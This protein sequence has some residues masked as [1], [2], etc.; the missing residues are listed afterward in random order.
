LSKLVKKTAP[1]EESFIANARRLASLADERHAV[2]I[3]AYDVRGMT[4]IADV[5]LVCSATS[6]PQMKAMFNTMR[7]GMK[8]IGVAPLH[9]EGG[10]GDAWLVLDYSDVIVHLF[11]EDAR[12]FYDLDGFWADAPALELDL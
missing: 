5:L 7:E 10:P 9:A 2:N 3:R 4:L 12:E 11:R 8:E 6:E 1:S